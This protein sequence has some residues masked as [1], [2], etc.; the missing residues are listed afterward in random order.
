M[1][2]NK[3]FTKY[4]KTSL[5]SLES[6]DR[7]VKYTVWSW[8]GMEVENV[9]RMEQKLTKVFG[10]RKNMAIV[11]LRCC[12]SNLAVYFP[13]GLKIVKLFTYIQEKGIGPLD[14]ERHTTF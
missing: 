4:I 8:R 12:F 13:V 5:I 14:R 1:Q 6:S 9:G 11:P 2:M 3:M 7:I 10:V